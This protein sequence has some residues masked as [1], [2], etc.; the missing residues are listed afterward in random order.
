[1]DFGLAQVFSKTKHLL[2]D[3][4]FRLKCQLST[5]S[6]YQKERLNVIDVLIVGGGN[7]ALCAALM[8]RGAGASVL[9]LEAAI[10]ALEFMPN[11]MFATC[12]GSRANSSKRRKP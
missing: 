10:G 7:A 5:V 12:P 3:C 1:M 2:L 11:T 8:A 6:Q 9:L 4:V